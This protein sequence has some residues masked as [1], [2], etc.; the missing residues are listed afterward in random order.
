MTKM[1]FITGC[2][3][4]LM[5]CSCSI[6]GYLKNKSKVSFQA[7]I[8]KGG[9]V[10]NTDMS[11][12]PGV[13]PAPESSIDAYSGATRIGGSAGVR[14]NVPLLRN[15]VETGL[16]LMYNSQE[17]SY[18]DQ[19]NLYIGVRNLHVSQLMLPVT[20]NIVLFR[21]LLPDAELQLRLGY[22]AQFNH[23]NGEG[24]GLLPDYSINRFSHGAT[25][26]VSAYLHTFQNGDK[27]GLFIDG[28]RGTQ[29]YKDHYNQMQF[30]MPGSSF[31]RFGV[32]YRIK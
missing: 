31:T 9:I 25:L 24:T 7:G 13:E 17:F 14:V 5:L 30:E 29:I 32:R 3:M 20:Y 16:D 4:L 15:E 8:N 26:G 12:V 1:K 18:A 21:K 6:T 19:G 28:Y 11:V 2:L 22:L 27:L 10:D 23:L